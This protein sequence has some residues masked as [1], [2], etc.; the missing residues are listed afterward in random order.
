M[1]DAIRAFNKKVYS[2]ASLFSQDNEQ[3]I[4]K[5]IF[6]KCLTDVPEPSVESNCLAAAKG[7][8]K[9]YCS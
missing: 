6:A 8:D 4:S 3:V 9:G 2:T 7:E 1:G 5:G